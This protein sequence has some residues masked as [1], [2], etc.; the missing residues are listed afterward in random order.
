VRG[1]SPPLIAP[2][3]SILLEAEIFQAGDCF[4]TLLRCGD[5][6]FLAILQTTHLHRSGQDV[7]AIRR[8]ELS[9]EDARVELRGQVLDM[10]SLRTESG[11]LWVWNRRVA[12]LRPVKASK[13][14]QDVLTLP[15]LGSAVKALTLPSNSKLNDTSMVQ[16]TLTHEKLAELASE[17]WSTIQPK[18]TSK[19]AACGV[20]TGFPYRIL[21]P[22]MCFVQKLQM[23][24]LLFHSASGQEYFALNIP[25]YKPPAD[26]TIRACHQCLKAIPGKERL[27]HVAI[28]LLRRQRGVQE[29]IPQGGVPV[30]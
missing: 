16:Y 4:A 21:D 30:S 1:Y 15:V 12:A 3:L 5:H 9:L 19:M 8:S 2:R 29:E 14:A 25:G 22:G 23:E 26:E 7:F 27:H 24:S 13:T 18:L 10:K 20:S 28:H 17:L 6:A 11:G